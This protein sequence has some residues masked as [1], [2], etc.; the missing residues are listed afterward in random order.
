M[1]RFVVQ[2]LCLLFIPVKE[3]QGA[4]WTGLAAHRFAPQGRWSEIA[5]HILL[6]ALAL[7]MQKK[8]LTAVSFLYI[9]EYLCL[10]A[11]W[12]WQKKNVYIAVFLHTATQGQGNKKNCSFLHCWGIQVWAK[13]FDVLSVVLATVYS[14]KRS[15][16][17]HLKDS[18]V[19]NQRMKCLCIL[20][21]QPFKK[22]QLRWKGAGILHQ[23]GF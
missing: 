23:P 14:V 9:F 7:G 4:V 13:C 17:R 5:I 12:E 11:L 8:C 10:C 19:V 2:L 15:E 1:K 20:R 3:F 21:G 18:K 6:P 22:A 16:L